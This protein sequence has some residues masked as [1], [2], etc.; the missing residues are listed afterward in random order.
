[1]LN[2]HQLVY[3]QIISV[4]FVGSVVTHELYINKNIK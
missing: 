1:M 4:C 2:I 3:E